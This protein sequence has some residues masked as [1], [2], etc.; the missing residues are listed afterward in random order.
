MTIQEIKTAAQKAGYKTEEFTDKYGTAHIGVCLRKWCW[1]WWE[2]PKGVEGYAFY[3][4][5]Y[6]QTTGET[7]K[8][9]SRGHRKTERLARWLEK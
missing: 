7:D 2:A 6:S 9:F 1:S 3:C 5:T 4:F 8:N